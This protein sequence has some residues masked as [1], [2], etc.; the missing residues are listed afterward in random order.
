MP[1]P[2]S[3]PAARDR[4]DE[5]EADLALAAD[6]P[7]ESRLDL[8]AK[9][10]AA[11]QRIPGHAAALVAEVRALRDENERLRRRPLRMEGVRACKIHAGSFLTVEAERNTLAARLEAVRALHQPENRYSDSGQ[12]WSCDT[13]EE[14][15]AIADC[16]PSDLV[17]WQVCA[18]CGRIERADEDDRD[19][20]YRES[21]WPCP[22]VRALDAEEVTE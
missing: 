2:V 19:W 21:L 7:D 22:T 6:V 13:P 16:D 12:E 17:A 18:E 1:R 11:R 15:A 3:S 9:R 10:W 5:I 8:M 20:A 4:L 14:A